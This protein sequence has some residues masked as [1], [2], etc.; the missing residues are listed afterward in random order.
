MQN[1]MMLKAEQKLHRDQ[2]GC[3]G[4]RQSCSA[5][6]ALTS[7]AMCAVILKEAKSELA[8]CSKSLNID[9]HCDLETHQV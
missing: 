4:F 9:W 7:T 8:S 1:W 6:T 3:Q 2:Q 5:R